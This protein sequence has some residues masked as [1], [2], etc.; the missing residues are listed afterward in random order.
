MKQYDPN[1]DLWKLEGEV[2]TI[3]QNVYKLFLEEDLEKLEKVCGE[4]AL[5]RFKVLLK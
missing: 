2:M 4:V 1:F 3:F 5:G